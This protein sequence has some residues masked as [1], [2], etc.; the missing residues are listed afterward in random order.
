MT[1]RKIG[2]VGS[3]FFV[4][5]ANCVSLNEVSWMMSVSWCFFCTI[6][7]PSCVFTGCDG[8]HYYDGLC[9]NTD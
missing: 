7:C 6:W 1:S 8:T 5:G 4:V 9:C 2:E 3:Y